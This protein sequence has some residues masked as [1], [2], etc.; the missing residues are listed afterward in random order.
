MTVTGGTANGVGTFNWTATATDKAG[1]SVS[2]TGTYKVVYRFDG[3]L[4]PI[5]DTA[6]Q[7]GTSTS[8]FKAGSTVPVKFQLKNA[9]GLAGP[10]GHRAGLADPGQGRR[11]EPAG[12]R[13]RADRVRRQRLDV[14]V[15]HRAVH[16]QLE[17]P[18][19]GGNYYQIG[20]KLDDGQT[21]YV[22]I[23]LK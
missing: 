5:N 2:Q 11:D 12:R 23:G 16:L 17:D 19:T 4:Q 7:V 6:H 8:V 9:V 14:Q 1:N 18:S 22:N 20:V 21:Y 15:R 10:V 3:F 13:D